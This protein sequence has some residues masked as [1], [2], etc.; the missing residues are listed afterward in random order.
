MF[1]SWLEANKAEK[2]DFSGELFPKAM[3]REF[4]EKCKNPEYIKEAEKYLGYSWPT[5]KATDYIELNKSGSRVA[6]EIP[7]FERRRAFVALVMGEVCEHQGRFIPEIVNGLFAISEE[8]FWGLS[9]HVY[10]FEKGISLPP[11]DGEWIDLF[12]AETAATLANACYLLESELKE[13][14]PEILKRVDYELERRIKKPYMTHIEWTWQGYFR[15]VNNWNPWILSNILNVFLFSETNASRRANAINKMLHEINAIY[16]EY[17]DDGGCDEGPSYW[18]VSGASLFDF[19]DMLYRSTNGK[20]NFFE[21]EKIR[22]I[23]EYI[24]KAYIGNHYFV[25]FADGPVKIKIPSAYSVYMFGVRL[26]NEKLMSLAK[27][28]MPSGEQ[29][30]PEI[31]RNEKLRR[32]LYGMIYEKDILA[33]KSLYI[34]ESADILPNT[35]VAFVRSG[36]FYLAAKGG[37]NKENH[38]HNDVGSFITFCENNPVLVDAGVGTYTKF[39]FSSR[40]YEIPAMQSAYHN[41]P[42]VNGVMQQDGIE[43]AADKFELSEKT[44]TVSF[45]GAYPESAGVKTLCRSVSVCNDG[46][47]CVDTFEFTGENKIS[48][49]FM[50]PLSVKVQDDSVILGD[51]FVLTVRGATV[52]TDILPFDGDMKFISVW[53][54]EYLTRIKFEINTDKAVISLRRI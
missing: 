1:D 35:Q 6:Q 17:P 25:N 10:Y 9:A 47:D 5:I 8:T 19:I 15:K 30:A 2:F 23:A 24:L 54:C 50:T 16:R 38:N 7:H 37:H 27:E 49:H 36:D 20:I 22:N 18:M 51:K 34:E 48:E 41:L 45:A 26:G 53:D 31:A 43:F 33:Q 28:I 12:A 32:T 46:V 42:L 11:V 13:Y 14:C 40:R 3:D 29:E 39:T 21:D 4:W 52:T 44:V